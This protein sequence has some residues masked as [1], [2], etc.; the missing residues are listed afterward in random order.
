MRRSKY[1]FVALVILVLGCKDGLDRLQKARMPTAFE[2]VLIDSTN[3]ISPYRPCEPSIFV[4]PKNP[5]VVV[6]GVVLNKTLR[7]EDGGRTWDMQLV[8]STYGVFGDPVITADYDGN[9]YFAHLA[10]PDGL[11]RAGDT[12]LDRI[13]VQK[14][15]DEGRTWNNGTYAGHR[16]PADQDKHWLAV[17]PRTNYIYMT[18]T[19]FDKY[20]STNSQDKSRI[21]FSRSA[22]QG[23][24]WSQAISINQLEGDCIDDDMTTEGAVPAV[25][26]DGTIYVGWSYDSKIY[27]DRSVDLGRSWME[28]D[29]VVT[30]QVGGWAIDIPGLGRANGMPITATDLSDGPYRGHIYINYC[31]QSAGPD[32]TDVWLVKSADN[33]ETWSEPVRVND[34]P[35]GKHQFFTWMSVDPITGAIYVVFYDRRNHSDTMTDVYLAASFDGGATFRNVKVSE[36]PFKASKESYVFFGDYNNISAYDGVVRPIWTRQEG[37]KLSVWTALIDL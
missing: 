21:L 6:A 24:S 9:F 30:E 36:T 17:D 20:G 16:P 19:E 37:R 14:S 7:S 29:F 22:D 10:D 8:E 4:S 11:G 35:P 12:W 27:F 28:N 5:D 26:P 23:K 3:T 25:G 1:L 15:T 2:N 18:W 33:G 34:D 32:D 13:V 31:D